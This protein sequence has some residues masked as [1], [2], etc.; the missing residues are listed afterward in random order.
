MSIGPDKKIKAPVKKERP[1]TTRMILEEL[2]DSDCSD[3]SDEAD[4]QMIVEIEE[5]YVQQS[6][7][8][9]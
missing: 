6:S 2:D 1:P 4:D 5:S 9:N 7:P 8:S 3:D